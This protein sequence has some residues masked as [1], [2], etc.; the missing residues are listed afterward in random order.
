MLLVRGF[1][2]VDDAFEAAGWDV[3]FFGVPLCDSALA[4]ALLAF[5][6]ALGFRMIADAFDAARLPVSFDMVV[7]SW[8]KDDL[9]PSSAHA[10][11]TGR[12]QP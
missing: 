1:R 9:S 7:S 2:S 11:A 12:P 5:E 10:M 8:W 3:T 6:L 4:A